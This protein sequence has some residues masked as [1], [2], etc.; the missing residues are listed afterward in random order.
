MIGAE[1]SSLDL[2]ESMKASALAV[3][4]GGGASATRND[5]TGAA[6][7]G[8]A[9]PVISSFNVGDVVALRSDPRSH[10]PVLEVITGG[11]QCRYRVFQNGTKAT[12]YESQLQARAAPD[13]GRETVTVDDLHARLTALQI[14]SPST[15]SLFSLRSGRVQF[16]PYQDRTVL[17]LIISARA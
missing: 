4:A 13:D 15:A 3:M 14:Q 7:G 16:V 5:E 8:F 9:A 2:I 17:K 6:G 10:L 1:R 12:Y 11:P